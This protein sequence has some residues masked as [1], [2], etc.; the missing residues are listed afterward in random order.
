V[1]IYLVYHAAHQRDPDCWPYNCD[2]P[3]SP[4]GGRRF[5]LEVVAVA[6]GSSGGGQALSRG[7]P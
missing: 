4:E 3:L 2:R 5:R 7:N 1:E 6:S